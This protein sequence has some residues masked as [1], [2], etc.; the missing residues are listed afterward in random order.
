MAPKAAQGTKKHRTLGTW[1]K[2]K[3]DGLTPSPT[4][5]LQASGSANIGTGMGASIRAVSQ[6]DLTQGLKKEPARK[7][8]ASLPGL[9]DANRMVS[10]GIAAAP[11]PLSKA[12]VDGSND[13]A[14]PAKPR[15]SAGVLTQP[16]P[17]KVALNFTGTLLKRLPEIVDANPV[18]VAS[19]LAKIIVEITTAV[20]DNMDAVDRRIASTCAQL[21]IVDDALDDPMTYDEK[22][23]IWLREFKRTLECEFA[24]LYQLREEW[25][26]RKIL[27]YED[28]KKRIAEIFER[29]NEARIQF[30]LGT[31]IAVYKAVNVIR[32]DLMLLLL[33]RLK[34]S[35]RADHKY[36]A[37]AKERERLGRA[38]CTPGTRVD[39][40]HSILTWANDLSSES[41]SVYWMF[42]PA[43]SG[44]STIAFTVARRFE[45]TGDETDTIRLGGNFLCS[46]LFDETRT[47]TQIVPT[48]VYH[49]ALR[50]AA[51]AETLRVAGNFDAIDQGPATQLKELLVDPWC[52]SRPLKDED[53]LPNPGRYL[54]VVDALDEMEG[55]D[56]SEFLRALLDVI[57]EN[58]LPGLKFFI[59]SRS[60]PDLVARVEAFERKEW[61]R[62]QDVEREVVRGDIAKYLQTNLPHF[63]NS[64]EMDQL[65][66]FSGGL[67]ICAVTLV[68]HLGRLQGHEQ[69][70]V[71]AS[72]F[73]GSPDLQNST[74]SA[75]RL[76]DVLYN[77]ILSEAFAEFDTDLR[78]D[79]LRILHTFLSTPERTTTTTV[80]P[81]LFSDDS[82]VDTSAFS[83]AA[84]VND[85][86]SRL[87]A[88]LYTDEKQLVLSYHKSFTDFVYDQNRSKEFCCSQAAL[89]ECLAEGCF[90]IMKAGLRFNMANIPSSFLLDSENSGLAEQVNRKITD[91]LAY[92]C[93]QWGFHLYLAT[94]AT[95]SKSLVLMLSDFLQLRA[96]FWIEAMN[97][98]GCVGLCDPTLRATG[99]WAARVSRKFQTLRKS[100]GLTTVYEQ[101]DT[102]LARLCA[103]AASFALYFSGSPASSSTPHLYVSALATWH[104]REDIC[105]RWRNYFPRIP[106][107]TTRGARAG[108]TLME[109][110]VGSEVKAVAVSEDG[111][112]IASGSVGGLLHLWESTTGK[113]QC[114]L[115]G[116]S[117]WVASVAF[118]QDGSR[119]V[120]G[121]GDTTVRVWDGSTGMALSILEGHN[122]EVNSVVFSR[123]GTRIVSGSC[124]QTVRVWDASTGTAL[125]VLEGHSSWV[126][127]VAFSRDG[128][129]IVS[130]SDDKTVR[131]WD[132]M[133]G[134]AMSKLDGHSGRV[135]SVAFSPD[136]TRIVSGSWDKTVRVWDASRGTALSVLKGHSSWVRSVAFSSER[137]KVVSGS[138]DRTVRVWDARRGTVLSVLEGH[139]DTVT[140]V[141]FSWDGTR[142]F[143][144]SDDKTVRVWD[145]V[146]GKSLS[147]LEGHS[148]WVTSVAFSRDGTR[149]VSA[150]VGKKVRVW[151]A[152]TGMA[153]SVLEGH[154]SWV[155]SVACSWDARTRIVTGSQDKTVKVWD[156]STGVA[157]SV[158]EG[159]GCA[160]TSVAWSG[161]GLRIVSGS[162]DKTVRVWDASTGMVLSILKGHSDG[163]CSV[164]FSRDRT[165]I[166]SGSWDR[167]VRVWDDLIGLVLRVLEGHGDAVTSVA[168]SRDGTRIVSGSE[169][170][171]VRVWN[172]ST[173]MVLSVLEGHSNAVRSVDFSRY[174]TRIVSGSNDK[175]VRVWD[176]LTGMVLSVLTGHG[177]AVTSVTF[178]QDGL[179]IVSGSDDRTVRVWDPHPIYVDEMAPQPLKA[180]SRTGWILSVPAKD[181]LMFVPSSANLPES[182]CTLLISAEIPSSVVHLRHAALGTEWSQCYSPPS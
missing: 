112:V 5:S 35:R 129:W 166:V 2:N 33:D 8:T 54:I 179:R 148:G 17:M 30:E 162:S 105:E 170:K 65:L 109:I 144:G 163:V 159:H 44:K 113:V 120:S 72:L 169:D 53:G 50:C 99:S 128:S 106:G 3:W 67:F 176:A 115:E 32:N 101:K 164:A 110:K 34:A 60:D 45:L 36:H 6:E 63:K 71:I 48:I 182:P 76:L 55:T 14:G 69:R 135:W 178:F 31:G 152:S 16:S 91:D 153:L 74:L 171:T 25:L 103:E 11:P 26:A 58:K 84:V 145:V 114:A 68:R 147:R 81:L 116:H 77:Q 56:G 107:F 146:T 140:S 43:G 27:D 139:T 157:L 61:C 177:D 7:R 94:P 42:G 125:S 96:L 9:D 24:K 52:K 137:T 167:T 151:D 111:R 136:G 98:L 172:T 117:E 13:H 173:G 28:E 126:R 38:V 87:H 46:R 49:L 51:F 86:L 102:T 92:S 131:V 21:K 22:K 97:L 40:I 142:I 82:M 12:L 19:S 180:H 88:V 141:A 175:T 154:S 79:R 165:R 4:P 57:R 29:V 83:S 150:S 124:D 122:G 62:L 149:I 15:E 104:G 10:Q 118:S 127:S 64:R 155:R 134:K 108:S 75:T 100:L 39:I 47:V 89:N 85:V 90:R 130:G 158:L 168:F 23:N 20:K 93:R 160:V 70:R 132:A 143:S 66:T 123:D 95:E 138:Q 121:S 78:F 1:I 41:P 80:A 37:G 156:A 181:R 18:K 133:T 174:G 161:D 119:I 73:S 59:T